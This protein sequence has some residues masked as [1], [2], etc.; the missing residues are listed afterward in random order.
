MTVVASAGSCDEA[1][2]QFRRHK[3][4][5]T[6]M[7]LELRGASG[8]DA[9]R[10]IRAGTPDARIVVLTVYQGEEDVHRALDA[11]AAAY[12]LKEQLADDLIQVVRD[13]FAGRTP[14]I[15]SDLEERLR[16]REAN[17]ALTPR[18]I[19]VLELVAEGLRNKEVAAV[20]GISDETAQVHVKNIFAK[21][22][23]NDRIAALN[24]AF[25]RGILRRG[26]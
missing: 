24:I 8:V 17:V 1:I 19:E 10:A 25:K 4:D 6:L 5:V 18:E 7:D 22:D 16:N 13:V 11:G 15:R 14:A 2:E 26:A 23:V 20:L 12:L 3:P 9:I 21:L